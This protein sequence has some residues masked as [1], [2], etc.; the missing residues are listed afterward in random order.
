M[1][2]VAVQYFE[3]MFFTSSGLD[4]DD[5]VSAIDEVLTP[6]MN[7][8]LTSPFT[9]MEIQQA[10]F[11][12][13]PS[14][15]PGPDGMSSFFFKKY[16]HIIGQ[17]VVT[18]VLSVLNSGFML[19]KANHSHIVL[20]PKRKNSQ[21]MSDY[22]PISLSNVVYKILSK[23]LANRMKRVLPLIISESQSAFVPG[24]Q[25]TDNINVAFELMHGLRNRRRGKLCQM[26]IKLDMSKAYDRVEWGFLKRVMVRMG[27]ARRWIN[28]M[29]MCVRTTSY[30]VLF[31]GEPKG[32]IKPSRGIRQGD[33]LSPYL[34]LL[35]AE[36][37]SALLQKAER[38]RKIS[39][40]SVCRGGPKISHLLFVDDSLLFCHAS[41]DAC[42]RLMEVLA[43]YE[44][45]SGQ[46]INKEK[47][48]LFFS[49]N[50]P[51]QVRT[52]IQQ[53]WGVQGTVNF[54]KYLGLPALVGKSKQQT[55][56]G[57][58]ELIARRL[59]GWKERLLSRAGRAILIKIVAQA[60]PTYTMSCF[61]LPKIWC[62]G[63]N[64][65]ISK[66]W[67]GQQHDEHKIHWLNW[68]CLCSSKCDGGM[69][70][71]DL[72]CFNLALL[73]KQGW[74]LLTQP[75]SLFYRVFQSKYFARCSFWKAKLGSNPSF[76]WRSI[77]ASRDL[78]CH[79]MKWSIG[80]G[81][82]VDI[83]KDDWG[84]SDL[85]KRPHSREIQ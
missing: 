64:S 57:L 75:A 65:M 59:Q 3:E 68:G 19:R 67:W 31:N 37:L 7:R 4:W 63:V 47:T 27:F 60:I 79:G 69:G 35:C 53:L 17:D 52:T 43:M 40:V 38:D 49:K 6:D 13:H 84:V 44:R 80:N 29:M 46:M 81:R 10:T 16:W 61:K 33:P 54:E 12:M 58:K 15:T 76:I 14:K 85:M 32:Y 83:W 1:S 74:R 73:A 70:F 20:V 78:L 48:A 11:Q 21:R 55:F 62:D 28:L 36:G 41:S 45:A 9:A 56:T 22:R 71:R 23:V 5:T 24:R 34:F 8:M 39:G 30:S 25:I 2:E 50:S 42:H 26:A 51:E 66:Y 77:L 82:E 72:Q 18:A